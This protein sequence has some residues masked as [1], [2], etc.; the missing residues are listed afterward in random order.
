MQCVSRRLWLTFTHV[1]S[2]SHSLYLGQAIIIVTLASCILCFS[3][4][5][6][7][8]GHIDYL[9]DFVNFVHRSQYRGSTQSRHVQSWTQEKCIW[10]LPWWPTQLKVCSST[11]FPR[12]T[13]R[14]LHGQFQ[15]HEIPQ[16]RGLQ[17]NAYN[18]EAQ[19]W[20]IQSAP[21]EICE[22]F[23]HLLRITKQTQN[24]AVFPSSLLAMGSVSLSSQTKKV[25]IPP[26]ITVSNLFM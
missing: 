5:L 9:V 17:C 11:V 1:L 6:L 21:L 8:V 25:E 2:V 4:P 12:V 20:R 16:H 13:D 22:V 14:F 19:R 3:F 23:E 24:V 18:N 26:F 15:L 10:R 7:N